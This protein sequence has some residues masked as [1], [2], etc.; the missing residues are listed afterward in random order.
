MAVGRAE[1]LRLDAYGYLHP[2]Y[3]HRIYTEQQEAGWVT[4]MT[5]LWPVDLCLTTALRWGNLLRLGLGNILAGSIHA[6]A[7]HDR[8]GTRRIQAAGIG[9]T[10]VDRK[11]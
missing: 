6:T 10:R 4:T 11:I 5:M 8:C 7:T 9:T 2:G 3:L 1:Q